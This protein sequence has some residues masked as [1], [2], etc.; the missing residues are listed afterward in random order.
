MHQHVGTPPTNNIIKA[1]FDIYFRTFLS[2]NSS[3]SLQGS[4]EMVRCEHG[5]DHDRAGRDLPV[6]CIHMAVMGVDWHH[7]HSASLR[8]NQLLDPCRVDKQSIVLPPAVA[9]TYSHNNV[10]YCRRGLTVNLLPARADSRHSLRFSLN[11][12]LHAFLQ[13]RSYTTGTCD[14]QQHGRQTS[15][16]RAEQTDHHLLDGS[17]LLSLWLRAQQLI[18]TMC[19]KSVLLPPRFDLSVCAT[20]FQTRRGRLRGLTC[21]GVRTSTMVIPDVLRYVT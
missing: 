8:T 6:S 16:V 7:Q 13:P 21:P 11:A 19:H 17:I 18:C 1:A 20:P 4:T 10:L 3:L 15:P 2:C 12:P 14:D 5:D 9:A